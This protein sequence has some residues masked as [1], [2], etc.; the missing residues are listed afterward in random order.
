MLG[1]EE[2][3]GGVGFEKVRGVCS[4]DRV[5]AYRQGL[6]GKGLGGKSGE[7][8]KRRRVEACVDDNGGRGCLGGVDYLLFEGLYL[9]FKVLYSF[10][11]FR[12]DIWVLLCGGR[13]EKR[14]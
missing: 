5:L 4:K 14:G 13:G 2:I 10:L 12:K 8:A 1:R 3:G 9:F 6:G 11:G 7:R